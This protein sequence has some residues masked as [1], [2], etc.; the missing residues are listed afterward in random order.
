LERARRE[1]VSCLAGEALAEV[2]QSWMR[3]CGFDWAFEIPDRFGDFAA[4]K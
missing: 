4:R 1:V 2:T 3:R